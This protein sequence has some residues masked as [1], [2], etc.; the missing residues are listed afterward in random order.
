MKNYFKFSIFL[1]LLLAYTTSCNKDFLETKPAGEVFTT[2]QLEAAGVHNP[3]IA[4]GLVTGIY[5][6]MVQTGTG[7]TDLQHDDFGQKGYDIYGDMLSG[8]MALSISTYGWYSTITQFQA[9]QDY[10]RISTYQVWRYYYRVIRACNVVIDILGGNDVVP[11]LV[12][13]Q[14]MM[15]QAK[16]LRAHAYFYLTQYFTESYDPA[17]EI[18]PIYI[19]SLDQNGPKV[20]TQVIFDQIFRDLNESVSLLNGFVRTS[21]NKFKIDQNV[22]KGILAYVHAYVG[23]NEEA[24]DLTD[25]IILTNEYPLTTSAQAVGGFN[26]L[27]TSS[28]MWGFDVTLDTGLDLVSWWGQMDIYTYSYAWAGD[29]KVMDASL[30]AQIPTNDIRRTQFLNNPTSGYHLSPWKKFFHPARVIGGQ[31]FIETDYLYMRIDEIYLLNAETAAKA[32]DEVMAR[33]R[34]KA[35]LALRVPSTTYVDA[36][37]GNALQNEIYKQTRI[38]LWGEGK[39]YLAVKRN[40][41]TIVRGSNHL[42]FVGVPIPYN[43]DRLTF[44]IPQAEVQNNPFID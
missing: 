32:G 6:T 38:E 40:H 12:E 22:A 13:N 34:L 28:W 24:K 30:F 23:N 1:V 31:R 33:Q 43:D 37:T 18:L 8:D 14:Y 3:E 4:G 21:G 29:R 19:T 17:A 25:E 11:E 15:G 20:T 9:T 26:D 27:N 16:A 36:L 35:L 7:G 42:S 5:S 10:T 41:A 39:A 2:D 44:P